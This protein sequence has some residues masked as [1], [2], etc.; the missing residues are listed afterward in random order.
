MIVQLEDERRIVPRRVG[1]GRGAQELDRHAGRHHGCLLALSLP[2]LSLT[3]RRYWRWWS[4]VA[5][6]LEVALE[7][8][9]AKATT[10]CGNASQNAQEIGRML[11]NQFSDHGPYLNKKAGSPHLI[12]SL[13]TGDAASSSFSVSVGSS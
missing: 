10:R 5:V 7:A 12:D 9:G 8:E 4:T 3:G 1:H 11:K 13:L 2:Q 6:K